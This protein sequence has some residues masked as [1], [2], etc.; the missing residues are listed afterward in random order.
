MGNIEW[1]LPDVLLR[2]ASEFLNRT[3]T[4]HYFSAGRLIGAALVMLNDELEAWRGAGNRMGSP[5]A[6]K[7]ASGIL[8]GTISCQCYLVGRL[9]RFGEELLM[10]M[11]WRGLE[12]APSFGGDVECSGRAPVILNG[13]TD[14]LRVAPDRYNIL[15][16][17]HS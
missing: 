3:P 10:L 1:G 9:I 14:S 15:A 7:G 5:D 17:T 16:P 8:N 11:K 4:C 6:L 2:G 13:A 12:G